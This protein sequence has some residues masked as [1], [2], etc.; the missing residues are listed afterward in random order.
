M[1]ERQ[2]DIAVSTASCTRPSMVL[3]G[4]LGLMVSNGSPVDATSINGIDA[5]WA[6]GYTGTASTEATAVNR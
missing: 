3:A 4:W 1:S 2:V 6:Q 5:A